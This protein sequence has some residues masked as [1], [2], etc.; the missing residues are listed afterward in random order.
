MTSFHSIEVWLIALVVLICVMGGFGVF[1]R[2]CAESPAV[3]RRSLENLQV[4]MAAQEIVAL[5]GPPREVRHPPEGPLQWIYG[6]RMK[7]H[8]LMM[9]FNADERMQVF[10]HGVP[11]THRRP[12]SGDNP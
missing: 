9:E 5:L 11:G 7:R 6:S 8:V 2:W 12:P 3:P 10:A 1:A 4:G